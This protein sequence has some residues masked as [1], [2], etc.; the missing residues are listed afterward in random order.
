MLNYPVDTFNLD[1]VGLY[2]LQV[3]KEDDKNKFDGSKAGIYFP[4]LEE[5]E[6]NGNR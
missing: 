4:F 3:K 6:K 5:L 1:N 2:T